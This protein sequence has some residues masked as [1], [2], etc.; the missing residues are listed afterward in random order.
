MNTVYSDTIVIKT[1]I[2]DF[3]QIIIDHNMTKIVASGIGLK[4]LCGLPKWITYLDVSNNCLIDLKFCPD[5]VVNLRASKNKIKTLQYIEGIRITNLG[6][7][8]N[9]LTNF[10]GA[11]HTLKS[12]AVSNFL[13]SLEGPPP[14]MYKLYASYNKLSSSKF[15]P[16]AEILD[17]SYN[18]LQGFEDTPDGAIELIVSN[19]HF[20][21]EDLSKAPRSLKILRCS[22]CNIGSLRE[23]PESLKLI[24]A[25]KND[26][27]DTGGHF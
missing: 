26:I 8:N 25:Y 1:P 4:S 15:C 10:A 13:T 12:V 22:S 16:T 9:H 21:V 20:S 17:L 6:I 14:K 5:S 7:S 18:M 11:P 24:E 27:R 23:Y 19:N 2:D 3:T